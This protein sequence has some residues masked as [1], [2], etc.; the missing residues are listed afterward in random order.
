MKADT[1]EAMPELHFGKADSKPI[2]WRE[3][4]DDSLDDDE[5]LDKTP[6]SVVAILGFDPLEADEE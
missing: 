2:N 6:P 1:R 4:K 3:Y 5:P